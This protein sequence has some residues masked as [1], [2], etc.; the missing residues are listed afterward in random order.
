MC[1]LHTQLWESRGPSRH[2]HTINNVSQ[3]LVSKALFQ[4]QGSFL[5]QIPTSAITGF[6]AYECFSRLPK[7]ANKS[8]AS[9]LRHQEIHHSLSSVSPMAPYECPSTPWNC[10]Q[11][12][13]NMWLFSRERAYKI[14]TDFSQGVHSPTMDRSYHSRYMC[15]RLEP[16][17]SV[18]NFFQLHPSDCTHKSTYIGRKNKPL[19]LIF[20]ACCFDD[21]SLWSRRLARQGTPLAPCTYFH[22]KTIIMINL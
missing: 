20:Y 2:L 10:L 7:H 22:F 9:F 11:K 6:K 18:R 19:C 1:S 14:S 3:N 16:H 17:F 12:F 5:R 15:W 21:G 4:I 13:M 8:K